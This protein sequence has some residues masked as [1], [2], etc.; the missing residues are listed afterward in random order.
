MPSQLQLPNAAASFLNMSQNAS[1]YNWA[2]GDGGSSTDTDPTHNY[3]TVGDYCVTLIA[4]D[5]VGCSDTVR[6]CS[7]NVFQQ[8]LDIPNTFTPNG[9]G[10][11]DVFQ[12]LGIELFPNNHLSIFNR[13]GNL[14]YEKDQYDNT[15]K[16]ENY[17]NGAPLPDGAYFY[18]FKTGV[19]GQEDIMG[20]V[21][22]FR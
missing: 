19:E 11:N 14:I 21:V 17:K 16:G 1:F 4:S 20:D 8:E 12:I 9:D 10:R 5:S 22:I 2:F 7:Y 13:W 3:T 15:W 18:I 6:Q